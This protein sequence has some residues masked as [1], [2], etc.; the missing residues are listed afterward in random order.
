MHFLI[1]NQALL[2]LYRQPFRCL[3]HL[4]SPGLCLDVNLSAHRLCLIVARHL[5]DCGLVPTRLRPFRGYV[6]AL[7]YRGSRLILT[8]Y[9]RLILGCRLFLASMP[10]PWLRAHYHIQGRAYSKGNAVRTACPFQRVVATTMG[11]GKDFG[12]SCDD[13]TTDPEAIVSRHDR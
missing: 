8:P 9:H 6:S 4:T 2:C 3:L 7:S 1:P 13:R 10:H 11:T 12:R 5:P